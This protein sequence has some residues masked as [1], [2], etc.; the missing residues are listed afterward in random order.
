MITATVTFSVDGRRV[1]PVI[2]PPSDLQPKAPPSLS[3]AVTSTSLDVKPSSLDS[4]LKTMVPSQLSGMPD[5]LAR[6]PLSFGPPESLGLN[7]PFPIAS[8]KLFQ[9]YQILYLLTRC[10]LF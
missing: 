1:S 7:T 8:V 6:P 5:S 9:L 4:K 2:F 3:A 10:F